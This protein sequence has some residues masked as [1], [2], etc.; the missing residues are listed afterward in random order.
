MNLLNIITS[1]TNYTPLDLLLIYLDV[2][3]EGFFVL[4][5]IAFTLSIALISILAQRKMR[6]DLES[7]KAQ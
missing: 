2:V 3:R 7:K 1:L 6:K 5:A 4:I